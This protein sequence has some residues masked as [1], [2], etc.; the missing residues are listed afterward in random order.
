MLLAEIIELL[1]RVT[2]KG[3]LHLRLIHKHYKSI[4]NQYMKKMI[5]ICNS[6]LYLHHNIA[7]PYVGFYRTSDWEGT[8]ALGHAET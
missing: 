3:T 6:G 7:C 4:N 1:W 8:S 5:N 2:A